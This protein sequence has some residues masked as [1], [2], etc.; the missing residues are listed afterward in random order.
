M[1]ES[2]WNRYDIL[3]KSPE[4]PVRRQVIINIIIK[5]EKIKVTL[6][7][8]NVAGALYTSCCRE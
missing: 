6:S 8:R 1:T 5:V 2:L 3:R 4:V 7:H